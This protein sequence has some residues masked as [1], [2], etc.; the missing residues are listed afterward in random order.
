ARRAQGT[1]GKNQPN[2]R[3]SRREDG[4]GQMNDDELDRLL[5][6]GRLGGPRHERVLGKILAERRWRRRM[7]WAAP[8]LAMA[9]ALVLILRPPDGGFRARGGGEGPVIQVTCKDGQLEACPK[10]GTLVFRVDGATAGNYL[11]AWAEPVGGGS[12][13]WY[14]AANAP[15]LTAPSQVVP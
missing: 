10:G 7:L 12:K 3:P 5:A 13:I 14:F 15:K 8:A 6:R 9:A 11:I 1:S 4:S 2:R